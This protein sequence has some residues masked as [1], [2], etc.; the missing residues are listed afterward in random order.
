MRPV[1]RFTLAQKVFFNLIFVLLMVAGAFSVMQLPVERYPLVNFGKVFIHTTYPG[2]SS[3]DVEALVTRKLEDALE[4]L[5][6]VEFIESRSS[7]ETSGLV[8][9]FLDDTDYDGLYDELRFKILSRLDE[10]P[11]EAD[12]PRFTLITTSDWL[13]V[14]SINLMGQRSNRALTLMA[15]E[16]KVPL[17]QIAGVQEV[18]LEGEYKREFHVY[19]DPA[20][21]TALGVTFNEVASALQSANQSIPAGDYNNES[22]DFVVRVDEKFRTRDQVMGTLVRT[23][24]DGSFVTVADVASRAERGYRDP[25]VIASIN[26]QDCVTLKILKSEAGNALDI[27]ERVDAILADFAPA[28][29][30]E[31]VQLVIT[32]DSTSYINDSMDT[33]G[34]NLLVGIVLVCGI[35]WY[36]MGPRNAALTTVGIPFSFL[37]TM[38]LMWVTDNSLNEITLFAFVLVSGIIVDDAIVVVE[39]IYRH[40]QQGAPLREAIV[41]GASEVMIP[42]ISATM[43]TVA[44]FLPMLI[45]TGPTGEF[46]ALIPKAVAF[47][48]V[49]SLFE[50][51]FILPLHYFDWG[52]RPKENATQESLLE[53][54]NALLRVLRRWTDRLVALTMRWR[55]SSLLL[56]LTTFI[57]AIV[58]M[59][60]SLSG[61]IPLIKIKFYP[62]DYNLYYAFIEGPASTNIE[63]TSAKAKEISEWIMKDGP[64]QARSAAGFAGFTIDEDYQQVWGSNYGTVMVTLPEKAKRDFDDPLAYLEIMRERLIQTFAKDGVRIT[65]R[66]EKDGPPT[67]KD[68]N[69]RVV[70]NNEESIQGLSA[71]IMQLLRTDP[72]L[73]PHLTQLDDGLGQSQ[74]VFRL[75]VDHKRAHEFGLASGDVAL[76][77]ASVL[78]GRYL[79]KFRLADEEVDLKLRIAPKSLATPEDALRIPVLEH[80]SGPVRLGDIT[81][82]SAYNEPGELKRYK[83]Q[84]SQTITANIKLGAQISSAVIVNRVTQF[85]DGLRTSFPGATLAFGGGHEDTKRSYISLTYAFGV[86]VLI[87]YLILA[88]QFKSYLQPLIILSAVVF[89]LIGV[90]YG[91]LFTQSLF[92]INSFIAVVGVTG[93]VVN[94]SLVLIDFINKGYQSGLTRRQ[95]IEHG[96]RVRLRPILLTTLTTTLGLLP[97]ALGFPSYSLV[98]GTMASTFVTGLA[99]ATFLTLFIVPVEWDLL[100]GLQERL[101]RRKKARHKSGQADPQS[102]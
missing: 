5:Q 86:A 15:K 51:L 41:N 95:A 8:I 55:I 19:L 48:I 62:D 66:A 4:D 28:L 37:V 24:L 34:W 18:K 93:V 14:V 25:S 46:F 53:E 56:V 74:R 35:I 36:F 27:K 85:Y 10:L 101:A 82:P 49:A 80:P 94:D 22:G 71:A 1:I 99:T 61:T 58:I 81:V 98:W 2:A 11:D 69:V 78:D 87:I 9:K 59:G 38:I 75:A 12:P 33:L 20:R 64:G 77:A 79:G 17:S 89:S 32:Q 6:D 31:G 102:I 39:N 73:A 83:G 100:M 30:K 29:D 52:P 3:T 42:V 13:P 84:R 68:V 16:M 21:L 40:V 97:M 57:T 67:G 45:M 88:T 96:I 63:A 43:T 65:V 44:A 54:D 72:E 91:K 50:C 70:G 26:G 92:T 76:M 23:D 7:H 60:V 90:V 47:A